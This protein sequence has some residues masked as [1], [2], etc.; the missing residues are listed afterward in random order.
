M[1]FLWLVSY[2]HPLGLD[3]W[4]H[5]LDPLYFMEKKEVAFELEHVDLGASQI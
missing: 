3:S 2:A 4:T 5:N 1:S